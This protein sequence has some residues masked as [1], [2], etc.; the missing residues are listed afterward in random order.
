MI[1]TVRLSPLSTDIPP[2]CAWQWTCKNEAVVLDPVAFF[3]MWLV[4]SA[5]SNRENL[6]SGGNL[7]LAL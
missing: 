2:Q 3:K 1:V 5:H 4:D 7:I 6:L